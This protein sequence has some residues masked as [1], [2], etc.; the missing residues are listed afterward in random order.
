M[1]HGRRSAA[2]AFFNSL[3][4]LHDRDKLFPE[5]KNIPPGPERLRFTLER[6]YIDLIP[7]Q[8][9]GLQ[10]AI[11][12][13]RADLVIADSMLFGVLPMLLSP[14]SRRPPVI[15]CSANV[16][17]LPRDDGAPHFGGLPP[18]CN[19]AERAQYAELSMKRK[20]VVAE[21]VGRYLNQC[22]R[23]L[24]SEPTS[25]DMFEAGIH[26]SDA[27]LQ[28]TVPTFEY[29]RR[30]LPRSLHFVGAIP[31]I[32]AQAPLPS[33]ATDLD[34][35]RKVVLVTQGTLANFNLDHLVAPTLAV[36]AENPNLLVVV[37]TGGRPTEALARPIP[38][39]ARLASYLPFDWLLPKVDLLVTNG[40]YGTVN[41]AL[42]HGIPLVTAGLTE[43][44]GEVNARV[45]WSGAGINLKTNEPTP[46][47]LYDA[48]QSVL[49][50]PA[51][52]EHACRLCAEF[53]K[54]DTP[55]TILNIVAQVT[56]Q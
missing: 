30:D 21:P 28:M 9:E 49:T 6:V 25:M 32:P 34:G 4:D 56:G 19:E 31:I 51:Y 43:D 26:L 48:I 8:H 15:L 2:S 17:Y 41:Q 50:T 53:R 54:I 33:W 40:G 46:Q 37:T 1:N 23:G 42:S 11:R 47:E 18:A 22:L 24:G 39:N 29:P 16:L 36:L 35:S 38:A 52:R 45:A 14:R 5:W 12:D 20:A 44:K 27:Y 7:A 55:R 13:F 3:L 10:Q